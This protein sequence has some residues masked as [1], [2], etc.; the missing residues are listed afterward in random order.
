MNLMGW[1]RSRF[2]GNRRDQ[3]RLSSVPRRRSQLGGF[4]K[5]YETP[6][7]EP[8]AEPVDLDPEL[9]WELRE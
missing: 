3:E 1:I 4:G 2:Y 7:D 6:F 9:P 5:G 8:P